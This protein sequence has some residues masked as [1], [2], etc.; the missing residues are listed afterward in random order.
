[1]IPTEYFGRDALVDV[2]T[3]LPGNGYIRLLD[4]SFPQVDTLLIEIH[5]D[6]R[7]YLSQ[8]YQGAYYAQWW[9]GT[10]E[11]AMPPDKQISTEDLEALRTCRRRFGMGRP[12]DDKLYDGFV[13]TLDDAL[14][15]G[16][17][18]GIAKC[19]MQLPFCPIK[20]EMISTASRGGTPVLQVVPYDVQIP[21]IK[22]GESG[23]YAAAVIPAT[24]A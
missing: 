12:I 21:T 17:W 7:R 23:S 10:D 11:S 13:R 18:E 14:S 16:S 19:W 3:G 22:P 4:C 6:R 15:T 1:M 9:Q 24:L 20:R 2:L 8:G 5:P